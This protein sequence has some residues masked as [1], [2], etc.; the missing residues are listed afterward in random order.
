MKLPPRAFVTFWDVHAWAGVIVAL[1]V[2][3]MFFAGVFALFRREITIWQDVCG[4]AIGAPCD[5]PIDPAVR[6]A[7]ATMES[8]GPLELYYVSGLDY[9]CAPLP[10]HVHA[11]GGAEHTRLV[12]RRSGEVLPERSVVASF[13]V[14]FHFLYEPSVIGLAG[15]YV[16][17]LVAWVLLLVLVT[18]VLIHLKD[19]VRQLH[20]VRHDAKPRV[21]WS[22]LHKVAGVMGIPFQV[23][24]ALTGAMICIA[25]LVFGLWT[26]VLFEGDAAR[27][28][29]VTE[30]HD[31]APP[32]TGE[33]REERSIDALIA[34]ARD[35]VPGLRPSFFM[36]E[37]P[38][39][40]AAIATV[41]GRV[42]GTPLAY[43]DAHMEAATG[44]VIHA[45]SPREERVLQTVE[46]WTY[47]LHFGWFGGLAARWLY[48]LLGLAGCVTI[49]SGNWIWIERRDPQRAR[50]S[51]H[52]LERLTIGSGL[53]V[54]CAVG[55]MFAANRAV[56]VSW[57]AHW[58]IEVGAFF[59]AWTIAVGFALVAPSARVAVRGVLA[60]AGA[61]FVA[62]PL[63]GVAC[64]PLH[65]A[66]AIRNG[67]WSVAAVDLGLLVL[68]LACVAGAVATARAP[69]T[70][71]AAIDVPREADA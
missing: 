20:R 55:A 58:H 43:G 17:G 64:T 54:A 28:A 68:G 1:L 66:A 67:A 41:G 60:T 29:R 48:A 26:E 23:S 31:P 9:G 4:H 62:T 27:A 3:A 18:G 15:M 49:L 5:A 57:D 39:D 6:G 51:T 19:L 10:V 40:A 61:M 35:V 16:A 50:R 63:L 42:D 53:G 69:S 11:A 13:L 34:D 44:R 25:G 59:A 46:R 14:Y 8:D 7:L 12:D 45:W 38:G 71:S 37:H 56:P 32:A 52:L 70:V 24:M 2:N 33:A 22:D 30:G 65:L 36:V 21:V 47:G